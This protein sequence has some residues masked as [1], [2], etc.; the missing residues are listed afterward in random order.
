[1]NTK[2]I[3][4]SETSAARV[5][6]LPSH[7]TSPKLLGGRGYTA[8]DMKAAFDRLPMLLVERLNSLI[9]D[10]KDAGD[11]GVA[12]AIPTELSDDHTLKEMFEDIRNGNF[13][14]YLAVGEASLLS[15]ITELRLEIASI[16]EAI[17]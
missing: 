16:K 13:A 8:A 15:V 10:I 2:K 4:T 17:K 14:S 11:G 9:D 12:A 5:A 1:M 6:S 7:P 3:N